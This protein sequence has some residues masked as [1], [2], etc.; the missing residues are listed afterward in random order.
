MKTDIGAL[1]TTV[2]IGAATI[3]PK[4]DTDVAAFVKLVDMAMYDAK[5][6]G[7]N[8]FKVTSKPDCYELAI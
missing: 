3:F 5:E 2:S 8:Q 7:R 4:L 1:E 6:K